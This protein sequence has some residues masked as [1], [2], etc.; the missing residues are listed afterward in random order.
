M[1]QL[2]AGV[3]VHLPSMLFGTIAKHYF[4]R[5][6]ITA[7]S[8]AR[9]EFLY[10]EA[11]VIVKV[12]TF[13][14]MNP[15]KLCLLSP[16]HYLAD[17]PRDRNQFTPPTVT[18]IRLLVPISCCDAAAP[19]LIAALG[20]EERAKEITGG[21]RWWQVRGIAGV[22]A[23]WVANKKEWNKAERERRSSQS[24]KPTKEDNTTYTPDLDPMRCMLYFHGG[25]LELSWGVAISSE[26]QTRNASV[27]NATLGMPILSSLQGGKAANREPCSKMNGRVFAVNYR[28]APQYPFP[29]Q[30]QDAIA[31]YLYLINPPPGA[32]HKPV[33]PS[34][35]VLNGDSAG[36]NLVIGLLQVIRDTVLPAPI[37]GF[38]KLGNEKDG[39]KLPMPAGAIL[40]SPWCDMTHSFP[41]T[42]ENTATDVLPRYGLSIYKPSA[43]WPPPPDEFAQKVRSD[44]TH[45]FQSTV[46]KHTGRGISTKLGGQDSAP[47]TRSGTTTS[48]DNS[49]DEPRTVLG[50]TNLGP[51]AIAHAHEEE[52][53]DAKEIPSTT[54]T[55]PS[56]AKPW[57]W[58]DDHQ[59]TYGLDYMPMPTKRGEPV[60]GILD[61]KHIEMTSQIQLTA[62]NHQLTHPLLSSV[63]ACLGGLCPLFIM[64]SDKECIRDEIVFMAHRAGNPSKYPLKPEIVEMYPAY[65]GIEGRYGPTDVHLQVYD[66][67][68]HVLPL[69]T[70][71]TPAIYSYRAMAAFCKFVTK[72]PDLQGTVLE[73]M[74][75]HPELE[76]PLSTEGAPAVI[77]ESP[78]E[79]KSEADALGNDATPPAQSQPQS[80]TSKIAVRSLSTSM[81]ARR[82]GSTP[83][84]RKPGASG[85]SSMGNSEFLSDT[86]EPWSRNKSAFPDLETHGTKSGKG[87]AGHAYVYAD[88]GGLPFENHML[89]ERVATNGQVREMEPE[90]DIRALHWPQELTCVITEPAARRYLEGQAIWDKKYA[91][92]ARKVAERREKQVKLAR[93]ETAKLVMQ[94][95]ERLVS[96]AKKAVGGDGESGG[97]MDSTASHTLLN[98]PSFS[99]AWAL[100]GENPPPSSL[101]ARRDTAEARRLAKAADANLHQHEQKLSG[102]NL[103]ATALDLLGH[104]KKARK[105]EE[106]ADKDFDEKS[107]PTKAKSGVQSGPV[108]LPVAS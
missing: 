66:E 70:F 22:D 54:P 99:W 31:A 28:L 43:L 21:T 57:K 106:A 75:E 41:S 44:L 12:W 102:N 64:A 98:E 25:E 103:W 101:V 10:D 17:I 58:G 47:S 8:K 107:S 52:K 61:G 71:T 26:A 83:A 59:P 33:P 37:P 108:A 42:V 63:N 104:T 32:L 1:A 80:Q 87:Y 27:F 95:E 19:I 36:G 13:G 49:S 92:A 15:A 76:R 40:V 88:V 50:D 84:S 72:A 14:S 94:M 86:V 68:C 39:W 85:V 24:T 16:C 60:R 67:T 105:S 89:R 48:A 35:I 20:G 45:T 46:S 11:F 38:E 90:A 53:K 34:Q 82:R 55:I 79:E 65:Q 9:D 56:D 77:T 23:N 69:F 91:S 74:L 96:A 73:P 51:E 3:S 5:K 62:M 18:S 93:K 78:E 4:A 2:V 97:N 100:E 6:R 81:F 7:E 29:C 30:L